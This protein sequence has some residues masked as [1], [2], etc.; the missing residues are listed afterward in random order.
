MLHH[1]AA[2]L[3]KMVGK[4][5]PVAAELDIITASAVGPTIQRGASQKGAS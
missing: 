3:R 5:D 4:L 2:P 1:Q